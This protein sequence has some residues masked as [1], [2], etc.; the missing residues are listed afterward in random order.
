MPVTFTAVPLAAVRDAL[1]AH[2]AALPRPPD[3]FIEDHLLASE[4]LVI[5]LDGRPVG[6]ASVHDGGVVTGF[7]LDPTATGVGREAYWRLRHRDQ[8]RGALVPTFDEAFLVHALD[9]HRTVDV[10][11]DLF[12]GS[13][14]PPAVPP[15]VELRTATA[16]DAPAIEASADGMFDPVDEHIA[17]GR[18]H[19]VTSGGRAVAYG[20]LVESP[21]LPATASLGV[22]VVDAERAT[23]M[24]AATIALLRERCRE[25]DW[26]DVAG[27]WAYNH[28][29]RRALEAAGMA[30]TSRIL[31]ISY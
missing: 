27:C 30:A 9:G 10:Q 22:L 21:L 11:A 2:A 29:S 18:L 19:V 1:A 17:G 15:G 25:Q 13:R 14:P 12:T 31:R 8:V 3:S 4:H 16:E 6:H 28:V 7:R 23:G 26:R 24:G 20:L 5:E